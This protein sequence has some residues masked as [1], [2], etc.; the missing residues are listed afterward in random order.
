[1]MDTT[2]KAKWVEALR[3][4]K[5]QQGQGYL[6]KDGKFCCLG[7]LCDVSDV[8][9]WKTIPDLYYGYTEIYNYGGHISKRYLTEE[10][11]SKLGLPDEE[12]GHF[13]DLN[14]EKRKDF[15]YIANVIE[16]KRT[17]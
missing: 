15:H 6:Q 14:D 13:A 16:Q 8:G 9:E 17:F 3:S 12:Q 1:M 4:G 2:L 11:Q 7:V 5:Y 10:L